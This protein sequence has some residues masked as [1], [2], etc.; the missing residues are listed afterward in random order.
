MGLVLDPIVVL[1]LA[2]DLIVLGLGA[3][4]YVRA[5]MAVGG[6]VGLGFAFFAVSYILTI[7]GYG[8][9]NALL[10]PLRVLGY[11]SVIAGLAWLL[12]QWRRTSP[13]TPAPA[14][15]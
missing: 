8:G 1:N 12:Y 5:G 4:L 15:H 10:L 2:F 14:R 7:L 11:V 6:L 9:S 3:F 13:P